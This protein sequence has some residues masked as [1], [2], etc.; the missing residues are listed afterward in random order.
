MRV[1][2][3]RCSMSP[4]N[5]LPPRRSF[6]IASLMPALLLVISLALVAPFVSGCGGASIAVDLNTIAAIGARPTRC[7]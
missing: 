6:T 1:A 4:S 7:A 2:C 3:I 5:P